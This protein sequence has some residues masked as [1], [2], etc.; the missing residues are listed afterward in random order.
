MKYGSNTDVTFSNEEKK[1]LFQRSTNH[2]SCN[3]FGGLWANNNISFFCTC[4][5]RK[6]AKFSTRNCRDIKFDL[7]LNKPCFKNTFLAI[8]IEEFNWQTD[9]D[10]LNLIKPSTQGNF[11][12]SLWFI[13]WVIWWPFKLPFLSHC[14]ESY[15]LIIKWQT[16]TSVKQHLIE[17]HVC[18]SISHQLQPVF[19]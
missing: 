11:V 18:S 4:G 14:N 1:R 8:I 19:S 10:H 9:L 17:V 15:L 6:T 7:L 5:R 13:S 16:R 3:Y 2:P 12:I